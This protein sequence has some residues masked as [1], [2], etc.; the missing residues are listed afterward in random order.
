MNK[1]FYEVIFVICLI[2]LTSSISINPRSSSFKKFDF[3]KNK[4]NRL[5]LSNQES[6]SNEKHVD[7]DSTPQKNDL[8]IKD[9]NI[10]P[11]DENSEGQNISE[12]SI[13][14]TTEI[15]V[16]E[17]ALIINAIKTIEDQLA[18]IKNSLN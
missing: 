14:K 15:S 2:T 9:P 8:I 17:K 4:H 10:N 11:T 18:Q 12:T 1:S 6:V 13:D 5:V 16:D 3:G 7:V